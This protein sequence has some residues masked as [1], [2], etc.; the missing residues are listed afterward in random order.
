MGG[1]FCDSNDALW[2][3]HLFSNFCKS[4]ENNV[5]NYF[6]G[7]EFQNR[8]TVHIHILVWL[9]NVCATKLEY[10]RADIPW[11]DVDYAY[12]L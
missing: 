7:F 2:R 11:A 3:S 8:G 1:Y 10:I 6:Y 9:K 4:S 5:I 12:L